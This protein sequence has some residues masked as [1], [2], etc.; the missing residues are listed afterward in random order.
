TGKIELR[1][2]AHWPLPEDA[3]SL[4]LPLPPPQFNSPGAALVVVPDDEVELIPDYE[5]MTG[6]VRQQIDPRMQLP[7]R[8]QAPLFYRSE[9]SKAVFAAEVRVHSQRISVKVSSHVDLK[10]LGGEVVQKLDYTI[11]YKPADHFTIRIP[12]KLARANRLQFLHG[13]E[14]LPPPVDVPSDTAEGGP[15]EDDGSKTVLKQIV[16]PKGQIGSCELSVRYSLPMHKL[17]V[18]QR[19]AIT[20][21]LIMPGEGELLRN[22]LQVT[23]AAGIDVASGPGPWTDSETPTPPSPRNTLLLSA[24]QRTDQVELQ[25]ELKDG[26]NQGTTVVERAWV[27]T[28]LTDSAR[29]DRAV[30]SFTSNCKELRVAVPAGATVGQMDV[31]LDGGRLTVGTD[32]DGRLI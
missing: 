7:S 25:V 28:W 14:V 31:W 23:A 15:N 1:V 21:P 22:D 17:R 26:T 24:K 9:A 2:G 19:T 12:Q 3:G 27:Q 16:L 8:Q 30:F 5:R 13:T 4:A 11:Q 10:K 29:Q 20:V 6:L 32:D 18:N